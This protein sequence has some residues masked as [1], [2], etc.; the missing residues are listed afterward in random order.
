MLEDKTR[1]N[2]KYAKGDIPNK[3]SKL[4]EEYLLHVEGKR[5][6]DI[7]CGA[8]RNTH[9]LLERGFSVDA[10]DI[11]DI[12]LLHVDNRAHKIEADLESYRLK[13]ESYDLILNFNFLERKIISDIKEALHVGGVIMFQTFVATDEESFKVPSNPDYLLQSGEL[14]ELFKG[15]EVIH[16]SEYND[17]N[18][19]QERVKKAALV[20]K[21]IG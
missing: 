19:H 14:L 17:I 20:A 13:K 7:A 12:A 2:E 9:Y 11:S 18:M 8:G 5:A 3:V 1:W 10:L 16:Y 15:F 6:L 4:L 21:K